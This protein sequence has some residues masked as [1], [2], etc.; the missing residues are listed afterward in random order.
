MPEAPALADSEQ[1]SVRSP[2]RRLAPTLE[3]G[4][5]RGFEQG[6]GRSCE[7]GSA[8]GRVQG[9]L[10]SLARRPAWG[11][12]VR[13]SPGRRDSKQST[14]PSPVQRLTPTAAQLHRVIDSADPLTYWVGGAW[15]ALILSG[16]FGE[17]GGPVGA[18]DNFHPA[19][20]CERDIHAPEAVA[21]LR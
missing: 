12:A 5:L 8:R 4:S 7:R 14:E 2:V 16:R 10:S 13:Q 11:S 18:V 15:W 20:A 17:N 9:H 6:P 3:R 21:W 1:S 19:S